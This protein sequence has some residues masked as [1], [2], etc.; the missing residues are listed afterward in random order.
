VVTLHDVIRSHY[1]PRNP[2]ARIYVGV[3]TPRA[4]RKSM[5]VITVSEA[6]KRAILETF[7][8]D[9]AKIVVTPNGVDEIFFEDGPRAEGRYFLFVGN[10][11]PHKNVG[12]LVEASRRVV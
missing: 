10:D 2:F 5:R 4:L 7:D 8:C 11:K 3:M 6:A 9:A 12:R 1:P